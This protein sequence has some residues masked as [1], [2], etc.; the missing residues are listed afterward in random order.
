MYNY[1]DLKKFEDKLYS[2]IIKSE[3]VIIVP[4]V[5]PDF[6]CIGSALGLASIVEHFGGKPYILINEKES[7]LDLKIAEMIREIKDDYNVIDLEEYLNISTDKDILITTDVN[8]INIVHVEKYLDRFYLICIL[9]LFL[10]VLVK[11]LLE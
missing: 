10:L 1:F 5:H 7:A 11:W 6:D 9:I 2:S 8:K 3:K 4:H